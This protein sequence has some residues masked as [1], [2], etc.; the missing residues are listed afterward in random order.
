M[1]KQL[2]VLFIVGLSFFSVSCDS[3]LDRQEKEKL[4][5]QKRQ[6]EKDSLIKVNEQRSDSLRYRA[7]Q[8]TQ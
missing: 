2:S 3:R 5:I 7:H 4:L 6:H 8:T 1:R